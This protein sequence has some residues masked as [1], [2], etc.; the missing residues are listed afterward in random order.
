MQNSNNNITKIIQIIKYVNLEFYDNNVCIHSDPYVPGESLEFFSIDPI[1]IQDIGNYKKYSL[2]YD[3]MHNNT[4]MPL[5]VPNEETIYTSYRCDI[6][7][8]KGV[9]DVS[10]LDHNVQHLEND[11]INLLKKLFEFKE[12]KRRKQYLGDS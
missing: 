3:W 8:P 5:L 4:S 11:F 7:V 6:L 10:I 2:F 12:Y 9:I 1:F